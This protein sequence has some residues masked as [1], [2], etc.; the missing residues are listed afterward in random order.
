M[1]RGLVLAI[2]LASALAGGLLCYRAGG[3][4]IARSASQTSNGPDPEAPSDAIGNPLYV[5]APVPSSAVLRVE[6]G[7]D[8]V[9]IPD[10]QLTVIDRQ[11]VPSLRDG[12]LLFV[13]TEIDAGQVIPADQVITI[14]VA[15]QT[16][17]YRRLK[18][19]D[20]VQAGQLL[21]CLDDRLARDEWASK[22]AHVTASRADLEAAIRA[23]DEAKN[24][25]DTQVRL[26]YDGRGAT[27]DEDLR[28]A[29]LAWDKAAFE[30]V[31]LRESVTLAEREAS[32]AETILHMHQLRSTIDGVIH[33]I[34]RKPGESV[35]A[36]EPV[37]QVQD[38]ARLRAEGLVDVQHLARLHV[39]MPVVLEP[40]ESVGRRQTLEGHL[41]EVTSVV[42]SQGPGG[43]LAVSGSADGTVRFWDPA[44]GRPRRVLHLGSPVLAVA[45]T[46]D[47]CLVGTADGMARLETIDGA[48]F[49]ELPDSQGGG[50][51]AVAFSP[52]GRTCATGGQDG[53]IRIWETANGTLRYRLPP[54]HLGAVTSLSFTPQARLASAGMDNT[55]C[56][57][58][59]GETG[60]R[61]ETS[62]D[63]RAG[64]VAHLGV[65]PDGR[66]VLLDQPGRL[67]LLALP[68]GAAEGCLQQD[69]GTAEFRGFAL[70]SPDSRL[71]LT[72][73]LT[74][75]ALQL[76]RTPTAECRAHVVA[77]LEGVSPSAA[78]CAAFAPN[79]SVVVVGT[80]DRQLV[81]WPVPPGADAEPTGRITLVERAVEASTHQVR[82]WAE[83]PNR[84]GRLLPGTTATLVVYP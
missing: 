16:K 42:V 75:G 4:R 46:A 1:Q 65:R 33:T 43:L 62:F 30:A 49:R 2:L 32:Q 51:T 72:A 44:T 17:R 35:K 68:D 59:L 82:I 45:C 31:S 74:E 56:V 76:W 83:F 6:L 18:E 71:V 58:A 15:E 24:R 61:L 11:D 29:R 73:S 25:Y 81:V 9:V 7:G 63:H 60:A 39:G 27:S 14:Q 3:Y 78:T 10:A 13:G 64:E 77:R 40:V 12:V 41:R 67:R 47:R 48:R 36:L 69:V 5:P 28:T 52:D 84:D 20:R 22:Q 34:L 26:R 53:S 57:W 66:Q 37:V 21:A 80:Q 23:S 55:V 79:G 8:P 70:F 38:L 54:G 19:G 50:V